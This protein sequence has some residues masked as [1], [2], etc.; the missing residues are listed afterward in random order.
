MGWDKEMK[1]CIVNC[2]PKRNRAI[3][4]ETIEKSWHGLPDKIKCPQ[5]EFRKSMAYYY[6]SP[7]INK[8]DKSKQGAGKDGFRTKARFVKRPQ[9]PLDERME[10]LY[11]IRPRKR[12][13]K[14][15]MEK[16]W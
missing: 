13:K 12:I 9:D 6:I 3:V 4:F 2:Y 16:I 14:E 1:D 8:S 7:L 5:T 15:D 11:E 10:K